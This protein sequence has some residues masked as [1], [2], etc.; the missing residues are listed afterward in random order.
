MIAADGPS[1]QCTQLAYR[2]GRIARALG[3]AVA[4][5]GRI[6]VAPLLRAP[7]RR[8]R[9]VVGAE[10]TPALAARP[11]A[12]PIGPQRSTRVGSPLNSLAGTSPTQMAPSCSRMTGH[13]RLTGPRAFRA[14][15]RP[16]WRLAVSVDPVA[17][18]QPHRDLHR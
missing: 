5:L 13:G 10:V 17:D 7:L 9:P 15:H 3:S 18:R 6:V 11:M 14:L 12:L 1:A 2:L 8:Q 16:P 4:A